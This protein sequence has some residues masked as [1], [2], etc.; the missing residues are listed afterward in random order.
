M[1]A[2]ILELVIFAVL[3]IYFVPLVVAA[4]RKHRSV[5]AIAFVN[6][7]LGWSVVGWLWAMIW[8]LTGNVREPE[9]M[10]AA[11]PSGERLK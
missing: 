11:G 8:S 10:P 2:A 3:A 5:G 6:I 7:V 4:A 1:D 9:K